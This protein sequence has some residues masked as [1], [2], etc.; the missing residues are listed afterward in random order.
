[1]KKIPLFFL[2][3]FVLL[4]AARM[5]H[6]GILW[7]EET[8]PLAAAQQ[9]RAGR[10]LYR[11][12]WFD[13]PPAVPVLYEILGGEAGWRL[14]MAGALYAL[15]C[16]GIAFGFARDLWGPRAGVWAAGLL[17]FFLV[18]DFP[19]S[20]IPLAADLLMLAPHMAAVWM[21][22][23]RRPLWAGALAG[24]AFAIHPKGLL[25]LAVCAWWAPSWALLGG[26]LLVTGAASAWMWSAGALP[27]YWDEVWR[28]GRVY[29]STTFLDAPLRNGMLRTLNWAGFHAALLV[30]AALAWKDERRRWTV[31][32]LIS[33]AGVAAGFRFFPR[34]Y[35]QLLPVVALLAARG[36]AAMQEK[37]RLAAPML[38]IPLLIPL[39]IPLVRFAPTYYMAARDSARRDGEWRD[40]AMDRDSRAAAGTVRA[41][42]KAGDTLF[43]WGY[44]PEIYVYSRLPAA[45][46]FLDSQPL[47]G[48]PADRHL[49]QSLPVETV[50]ANARRAELA[51]ARPTFIVDG[52][53]PYNPR[54]ALT[55]FADLRA[56]TAAYREVGRSAQSVIYRRAE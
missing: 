24:V 46:R 10:V 42:A 21:A 16:C 30:A 52:L 29:A 38:L 15:L 44:R 51:R 7:A 8:L 28:W 9:M 35:F 19:S 56:W 11:D 41:L 2:L 23:K 26:W 27:G 17:G 6:V 13:K 22:W 20:A 48:V 37:R 14:R 54:L 31:W 53:G 47:T 18:F 33:L 25:V 36:F 43:V 32:L 4:V 40:T 34:Y 1:V 49:T 55:E 5:C 12:I 45:T 39:V 50:E 3:L